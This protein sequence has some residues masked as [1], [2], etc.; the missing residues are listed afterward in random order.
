[1]NIFWLSLDVVECAQ[2]YSDKHV[3]KIIL[4][5]TQMLYAVHHLLDNH[6]FMDG[7]KLTHGLHPMTRWVG[8]HQDNYMRA[9]RLGLALCDEYSYRYDN[10]TH[11]CQAHLLKLQ[12]F[13]PVHWRQWPERASQPKRRKTVDAVFGMMG[14]MRVP[15]CMPPEFHKESAIEAYR[16]YY[17][18]EEKSKK[19]VW[20]RNRSPPKWY[21]PAVAKPD[22][23][24]WQR[25]KIE[26]AFDLDLCT[27]ITMHFVIT[28]DSTIVWDDDC[29]DN[30]LFLHDATTDMWK[31]VRQRFGSRLRKYKICPGKHMYWPLKFQDDIIVLGQINNGFSIWSKFTD[32]PPQNLIDAFLILLN[33]IWW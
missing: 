13:E 17:C 11:K 29:I 3:V 31:R 2:A 22:H 28:E 33:D 15:L 14:E 18:G 9:V 5:I 8:Q 27:N 30:S 12:Q 25:T 4:E 32:K 16:A 19:N 7:Y 26:N 20:K 1:M 23:H 6:S 24:V 21:S 10:K